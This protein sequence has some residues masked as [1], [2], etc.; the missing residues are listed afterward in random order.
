[1]RCLDALSAEHNGF[2][3]WESQQV[4]YRNLF[5]KLRPGAHAFVM[6][7]DFDKY[8]AALQN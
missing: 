7:A 2:W 3:S 8:N 4:Y 1:M 5:A 6:F